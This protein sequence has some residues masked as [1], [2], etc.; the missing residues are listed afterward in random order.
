MRFLLEYLE[1]PYEDKR[2]T[3]P[4]AW[5][6]DKEAF[7]QTNPLANL[8]Y[9]KDGDQVIFESGAIAVYL[10]QKANRHDLFGVDAESRV[11]SAQAQGVAG[12]IMRAVG[13]ILMAG[14]KEDF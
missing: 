14:T 1:I 13:P 3:S 7:L 6:Q 10:A 12:D 2:Y 9:L 5:A 4:E 8:P 11:L